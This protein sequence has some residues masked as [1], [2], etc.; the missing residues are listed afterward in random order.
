M[1]DTARGPVCLEGSKESNGEKLPAFI[2]YHM[3]DTFRH[4][5]MLILSP[6]LGGI[7]KSFISWEVEAQ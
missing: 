5:Y 2:I 4:W 3:L 6:S 7:M 1:Q